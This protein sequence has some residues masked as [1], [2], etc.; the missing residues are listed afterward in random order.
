MQRLSLCIV[1]NE[2]NSLFGVHMLPCE[3]GD[4]LTHQSVITMFVPEIDGLCSSPQT[5]GIMM[6]EV[7]NRLF[8]LKDDV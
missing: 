3:T 4:A 7:T 2:I 8:S 5:G 1:F 6:I